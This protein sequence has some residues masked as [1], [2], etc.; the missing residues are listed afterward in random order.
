MSEAQVKL[1]ALKLGNVS[2]KFGAPMGRAEWLPADPEAGG[3]L[4]LA[5]VRFVDQCYDYGGAYWGMPANLYHV[6]GE[7]DGDPAKDPEQGA[8]EGTDACHV[9]IFVRASR[10][11][12][13]KA[14]VLKRFPN[15]KFYR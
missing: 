13:A 9:R 15:V 7:M 4:Q 12:A 1:P 6:E 8:R 10:R 11:E 5:Y 3:K 14:E 2:A